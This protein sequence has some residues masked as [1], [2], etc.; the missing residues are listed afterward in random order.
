MSLIVVYIFFPI[1]FLLSLFSFAYCY[2]FRKE[3][4]FRIRSIFLIILSNI[5]GFSSSLYFA[6]SINTETTNYL[7]DGIMYSLLFPFAFCPM[8]LMV[9]DLIIRNYLNEEKSNR[10]VGKIS[11]I[12]KLRPFLY[13]HNK[14]II[15][16]SLAIIQTSIYLL[17]YFLCSFNYLTLPIFIFDAVMIL[18]FIPFAFII[19][20]ISKISDPFQIKN[21]LLIIWIISS[22]LIIITIIYPFDT[23]IFPE[24]FDFRFIFITSNALMFIWNLLVVIIYYHYRPKNNIIILQ[25]ISSFFTF[26]NNQELQEILEFSKKR[27]CSENIFAYE[28]ICNFEVYNNA[29]IANR[30][31]N[32]YIDFNSPLQVN[33][34]YKTIIE[35]QEKINN[36]EITAQL[37]QK[38][39]IELETLLEGIIRDY[40]NNKD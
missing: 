32:E 36:N 15:M 24:Y 21:Q 26:S 1:W 25:H 20:K 18:A 40:K 39:K 34:N 16:F 12:W 10:V 31:F 22:P 35:V 3:H 27:W 23:K 38:V 7:A 6:I 5:F 11:S 14:L 13:L 17:F 8:V 2:Y 9:P 30:I 19:K 37:F 29:E 4:F 33:L 28:A